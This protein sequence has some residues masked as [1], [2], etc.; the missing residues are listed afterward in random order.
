MITDHLSVI[1]RHSPSVIARHSSA[2][3]IPPR[4]DCHAEPALSVKRFFPFISFRVRMTR[5]EG[6]RVRASAQD[7]L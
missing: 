7:R 1:A 5:G 2:E 4:R 3:A 6:L